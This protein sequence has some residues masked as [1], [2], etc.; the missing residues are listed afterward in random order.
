[1]PSNYTYC[2]GYCEA[3]SRVP[4]KNKRFIFPTFESAARRYLMA[5]CLLQGLPKESHVFQCHGPFLEKKW[6]VQLL[7]DGRKLWPSYHNLDL[8]NALKGWPRLSLKTHNV[9]ISLSIQPW[10]LPSLPQFWIPRAS[11]ICLLISISESDPRE[12]N[13][14]YL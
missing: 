10:F 14:H 1:M 9:L 8:K 11:L 3:L 4:F 2:E 13:L 5:V 7:R 6:S 12:F